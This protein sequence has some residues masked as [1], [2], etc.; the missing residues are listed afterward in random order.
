MKLKVLGLDAAFAHTGMAFAE[1]DLSGTVISDAHIAVTRVELI[2]TEADKE[3]KKVVRKNSDDLRR[4][5]EIVTGVRQAVEEHGIHLVCCEVPTGTQS[6]RASWALGIAV[7]TL[8]A[9]D[10][11]LI[12]V[13]PREVKEAVGDKYADKDE[14]IAWASGKYPTINWPMSKK[15]GQMSITVGQ[16]EHMADAVA[17]IHAATKTAEFNRMAAVY[18]SVAGRL[19]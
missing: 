18:R 13:L 8:A 14:I 16:A 4:A 5:R 15:K 12:Q 19:S 1:V 3:S 7:G 6:A 17:V 9:I 10:Q 11:P 2:K